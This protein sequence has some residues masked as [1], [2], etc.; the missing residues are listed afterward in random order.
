MNISKLKKLIQQRKTIEE[1]ESFE[2][3]ILG[4]KPSNE[5]KSKIIQIK[6]KIQKWKKEGYNVADLEKMIESNVKQ[7]LQLQRMIPITY[8]KGKIQKSPRQL[9]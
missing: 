4:E 7:K 2:D 5:F 3:D 6:E 8:K 9:H 1:L